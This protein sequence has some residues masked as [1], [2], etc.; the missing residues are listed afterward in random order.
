MTGKVLTA[1]AQA[2]LKAKQEREADAPLARAD[3]EAALQAV[4]D[5]TAQLRAE[6]L[7]REAKAAALQAHAPSNDEAPARNDKAPAKKAPA[8]KAPAKKAPARKSTAARKSG[9][10]HKSGT[11]RAR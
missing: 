10:A 5:R 7:A 2:R 8:R 1:D 6:R 11:A 9:T 3:Y 4:L